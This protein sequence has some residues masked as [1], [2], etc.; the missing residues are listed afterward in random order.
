M[1]ANLLFKPFKLPSSRITRVIYAAL[2]IISISLVS[3]FYGKPRAWAVNE[4]PVAFW[5][6]RTQSPADADL[7]EAI[8]KTK[9]ETVFLRAG[10]FDYQNGKLLR[11]RPL[12]G[13]FPKG[14][15]LHLVYNTTRALLDQLDSVEAKTLAGEIARTYQSDSERARSDGADLSGLQLDIDFPTRLLPHYENILKALRN[16]LPRDTQLSITGLPTWMES[17]ALS[18]VLRYV[19]F[20]I[21]QFYGDEIAQR[22]EQVIPI[23]SP[24][25]INHFVNKARALDRPFYAGLAAYSVAM[26]YSASGAL[27]SL[28]GDMDPSTVASDANLELVDQRSFENSEWR[29]SFRAKADG[30]T[31]GLNMKAGD[32]LVIDMPSAESLRVAARV[33]RELAGRKL[34]GICVFRLP[35][36]DDAAT[37]TIEQVTSA[38]A[39]ADSITDID[40]R[41]RRQD[42]RLLVECK[43][44]GTTG[45]LIGTL[46]VDVAVPPGGFEAMNKR[47]RIGVEPLCEA[48]ASSLEPC[49]QR[50][51]NVFRLTTPMLAPSQTLDV[52]LALNSE[53]PPTTT[54]TITMQT[55]SGRLYSL[56]REI[57]IEPGAK[58]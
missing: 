9:A 20:W 18:S 14:I 27:I 31:D 40:V 5:A 57:L 50:R 42:K 48:T 6:W 13:S 30:V 11:I 37:L 23:S 39:D 35:A 52:D 17:P 45:P 55:D 24:A 43:N 44:V 32:V 7:R 16:Y 21:P 1:R 2:V 19:D 4:V 26:L 58:Q 10:Q 38:L 29:Y 3:I 51:A 28:R 33:T 8:E 41:I 53:P 36:R 49:S 12:A 46:K 47:E 56:Q 22:Y 34:L 54:V 15:K 25:S